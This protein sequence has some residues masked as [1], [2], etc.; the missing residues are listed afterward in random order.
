MTSAA[1]TSPWGAVARNGGASYLA[2]A[3]CRAADVYQSLS[4]PDSAVFFHKLL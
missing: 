3:T 4:E 2:L 1:S